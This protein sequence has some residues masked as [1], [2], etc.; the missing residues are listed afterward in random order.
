[1]ALTGRAPLVISPLLRASETERHT[2]L[3]DS[4]SHLGGAHHGLPRRLVC[5][6]S[7][8]ADLVEE[9]NWARDRA[10]NRPESGTETPVGLAIMLTRVVGWLGPP[11]RR[12]P[13]PAKARSAARSKRRGEEQALVR[14]AV[15]SGVG[16]PGGNPIAPARSSPSWRTGRPI[17]RLSRRHGPRD[18]V[19]E[20]PREHPGAEGGRP[21]SPGGSRRVRA[22]RRRS[23]R[24]SKAG[25]SRPMTETLA[26]RPKAAALRPDATLGYSGGQVA[27]LEGLIQWVAPVRQQKAHPSSRSGSVRAR[28]AGRRGPR[29]SVEPCDGEGNPARSPAPGS[30]R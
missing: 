27:E 11:S 30:A 20:D 21:L 28:C 24:S 16:S 7:A 3:T 1:M 29:G 6:R 5:D 26:M 4:G 12:C 15:S 17:T 8:G 23:C 19:L 14:L 22:D 9:A 13:P 10:Q 25:G 2:Y 18:P